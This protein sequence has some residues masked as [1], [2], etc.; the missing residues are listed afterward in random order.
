[1]SIQIQGSSGVVADVGGSGYRALKVQCMPYE[2]GSRGSFKKSL[3]TGTMATGLGAAAPIFSFRWTD[4]TRLAV[5]TKVCLDGLGSLTGFTAGQAL[6]KLFMARAFSVVDSGG[7]A[8]ALTAAMTKLR[9]SMGDTLLGDM[10]ISSTATLT[11][12]T[13]T[14]DTDPIGQFQFSLPVT[15]NANFLLGQAPLLDAC[16]DGHPV[17]LAGTGSSGEG[18]VI[19]ATVPATGTWLSGVT[20]AW[21]EVTSF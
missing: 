8:G 15:A 20:I 10:R 13:R 21:S 16:Q 7:T 19:Q 6:F 5:V 2:F 18:L 12:G 14:L 3:A 17:V 9:T 4:A 1:M 11:A